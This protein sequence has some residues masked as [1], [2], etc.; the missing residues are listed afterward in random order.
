[1][2]GLPHQS[3]PSR[4]NRAWA[5]KR[6]GT[7]LP[8]LAAILA[9]PLAAWAE[10]QGGV[11][12]QGDATISVGG[13]QTTI[14]QRSG[15]AI[16]DWQKFGLDAHESAVFNQ[17]GSNAIA[18]NRV[19]GG[20]PSNILGAI[21]A[22]GQVWLV[23]RNGVMFGKSATVDVHG[24][25]ATT[26][27]I[28][29]ASFMAD[30]FNFSLPAT[31]P[32]AAVVNEGTISF[33]ERG[34]TALVGSNARNAGTI[35]GRLGSVVIAG[36]PT[37]T[38][39]LDPQDGGLIQFAATSK[40]TSTLTGEPLVENSG[41]IQNDGGLVR[42]T[43][44]A[45]DGVVDEAINMSGLIEAHGLALQDGRVELVNDTAGRVVVQGRVDAGAGEA[46]GRE[47]SVVMRGEDLSLTEGA[48]I[49]GSS[50]VDLDAR[51]LMRIDG[52]IISSDSIALAG[53]HMTIGGTVVAQGDVRLRGKFIATAG[54]GE[55][56]ANRLDVAS[57][58][59]AHHPAGGGLLSLKTDVNEIAI[60]KT[61][62]NG[63][64]FREATVGNDGDLMV[65]QIDSSGI[66]VGALRLNLDGTLTVNRPIQASA[67]GD[68][69][70]VVTGRFVNGVGADALQTPQGR[71]LVYSTDPNADSRG[72]LSGSLLFD[73]NFADTPPE[74][75]GIS[76]NV[77]IYSGSQAVTPP[78][79]SQPAESPPPQPAEIPPQP[80]PQ[81]QLTA[82]QISQVTQPTVVPA[83]DT[84]DAVGAEGHLIR[85]PSGGPNSDQ[86]DDE[87]L[88]FANDGN[89]ELWGLGGGR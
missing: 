48:A 33:G 49:Q 77:F 8:L 73:R 47:G 17:P 57:T 42:L 3:Q 23:N 46:G 75:I 74:T 7:A 58:A 85:L 12:K 9:W 39:A 45:A 44:S 86:S 35:V 10:P 67:A 30:D 76:G 31:D 79:P 19:T 89:R 36:A 82:F 52:T 54:D 87:D 50:A 51:R 13:S 84:T 60:G 28:P 59:S 40:V 61:K 72:D 78:P 56:T 14:D 4:F 22:N 6:A 18:L 11:V 29:N 65:S 24:L 21:R 83:S 62:P 16:I 81:P 32:A 63:T 5:G 80:Q 70:V 88:L 26:A 66:D 53:E 55:I 37:F 15:K 1:M 64:H 71:A 27:D 69:V 38:I 34:L 2:N 20:D 41:V 43:A 25:V 68:A